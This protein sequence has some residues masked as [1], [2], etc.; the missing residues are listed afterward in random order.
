MARKKKSSNFVKT[1]LASI[2]GITLP[3]GLILF[4]ALYP[5]VTKIAIQPPKYDALFMPENQVIT[6][7]INN[8]KLEFYANLYFSYDC[9]NNSTKLYRFSHLNNTVT[10]IPISKLSGK[11]KNCIDIGKDLK[12]SDEV[13]KNTI[14]KLT[15]PEVANLTI[16]QSAL[17]PDGYRFIPG[18]WDQASPFWMLNFFGS[19][20]ERKPAIIKYGS[21]IELQELKKLNNNYS[22]FNQ[23]KF[24]GWIIQ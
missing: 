19:S 3:L 8:N 16:N 12:H 15:I 22:M 24:I 10:E 20:E 2:I 11:Q 1:H 17:S 5:I 18:G 14:T 6:Y 23:I 9:Y 13:I 21:R 7:K 4:F